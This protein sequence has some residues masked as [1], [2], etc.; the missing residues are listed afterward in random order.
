MVGKVSPTT[1][2]IK[3]QNRPEVIVRNSD[4]A[5]LGTRHECDTKLGQY[6][7]RRLRKIQERTLE[8]KISNHRK[9]LL[10]KY[11]GIKK[12][13]RTRK[14]PDDITIISFGRSC[15]STSSNVAKALKMRIF[16]RNPKHDEAFQ[17]RP[18]L[19]QILHFRPAEPIA[20]PPSQPSVAGP[21]APQ[22]TRILR[23]EKRT[24]QTSDTV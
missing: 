18:D 8:Q 10:G 21:S 5:K 17:N 23:R 20:A 7:D 13:K 3:E 22:L 4:I 9:E 12:I 1:S 6:I 15:I 16:K 2:V 14:Q 19:T 11:L 24:I